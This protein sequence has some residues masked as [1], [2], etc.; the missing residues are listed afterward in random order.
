MSSDS[1]E[2]EALFDSIASAM[3]PRVEK[4]R[5]RD[6]Q[7]TDTPELEALFD[8]IAAAVNQ[9]EMGGRDEAACADRVFSRIGQ[10]T[11]NLHNLLR[12]L[13]L[14]KALEKVASD[15]P[16]NRDRLNYIASMT[17][18][19]AERTLN[20]AEN[21]Q[22]VQERMGDTAQALSAQW[23]RLFNKQLGV[24]EFK[25]LVQDTRGFL[26]E[27]PRHTSATHAQLM[28]IILAQDFQDLTG[29]VIKKILEAAQQLERQLLGLLIETTPQEL[30]QTVDTG[31]L[32]GPVIKA[33]GRADV[34]TNQAQVDELLESLGF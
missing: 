9:E 6:V 24:D 28:E 32:N 16:D 33:D 18:K 12:E 4:A 13:G 30:R 20:A 1:P 23:D 8:S 3:P 15:L 34:V 14:D 10:M 11:R 21:A 17:A 27:I 19:A 26:A 25:T 5:E 29:Q 7:D 22:P 2:L 31:L